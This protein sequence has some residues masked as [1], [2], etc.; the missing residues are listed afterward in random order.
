MTKGIQKWDIVYKRR[1]LERP[2]EKIMIVI[3][4]KVKY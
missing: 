3:K 4:L 2:K 1:I